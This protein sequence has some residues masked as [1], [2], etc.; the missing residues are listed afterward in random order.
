MNK[1]RW[2]SFSLLLLFSSYLCRLPLPQCKFHIIISYR[3]FFAL[4][5][6]FPIESQLGFTFNLVNM[7]CTCKNKRTNPNCTMYCFIACSIFISGSIYT[8]YMCTV[9]PFYRMFKAIILKSNF[10]EVELSRLGLVFL[11]TLA[12]CH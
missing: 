7:Q 12:L 10:I 6:N 8:L 1:N 11:L 3:F 5:L 2:F 4:V 9:Q